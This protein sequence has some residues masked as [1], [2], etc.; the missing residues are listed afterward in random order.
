[1]KRFAFFFL[2]VYCISCREDDL[3]APEL[4]LA[5]TSIQ[6]GVQATIP[7]DYTEDQRYRFSLHLWNI[8]QQTLKISGVQLRGERHKVAN[9]SSRFS[10][11][12]L[13]S[14]S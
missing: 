13:G 8:G 9:N 12:S 7:E 10:T 5:T 14:L 6:L 2:L 4:A 1:M 11:N 3:S